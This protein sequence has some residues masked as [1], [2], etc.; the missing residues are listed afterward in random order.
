MFLYGQFSWCRWWFR[1][2][3]RVF[4]DVTTQRRSGPASNARASR[5]FRSRI[6][7]GCPRRR[8]RESTRRCRVFKFGREF[9]FR[10]FRRGKAS[11][12]LLVVKGERVFINCWHWIS[13]RLRWYWGGGCWRGW[14]RIRIMGGKGWRWKS[15]NY[16]RGK[17][18][19]E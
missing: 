18:G 15:I 1:S 11:D 16:I 3:K 2:W 5:S 10:I 8:G 7:I 17:Q 13:S 12:V 14:W 19:G 6:S 9:R 4:G